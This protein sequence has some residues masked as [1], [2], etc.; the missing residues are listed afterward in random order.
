MLE[1]DHHAAVATEAPLLDDDEDDELEAMGSGWVACT[2]DGVL[3]MKENLYDVIVTMPPDYSAKAIKKVW[4]KI[5]SPRGTEM[6]A[7][8]RDLRRYVN[9]RRDLAYFIRDIQTPFSASDEN[10][11]GDD[12]GDSSTLRPSSPVDDISSVIDEKIVE[13]LSWS[14]LAYTGF[15]WWASAGERRADRDHEIDHDRSL[16]SDLEDI[17]RNAP[18]RPS[19]GRSTSTLT[20]LAKRM[21]QSAAPEMAIIVYFRRLTTLILC[22]LADIIDSTD[23]EIDEE[24]ELNNEGTFVSR[25]DLAKMG[26]DVWSDSDKAFVENVVMEYFGRHAEVDGGKIECC[27]VRIC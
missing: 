10:G 19:P 20:M 26:L 22:T 6:K 27:G 11:G 12:I 18:T 7:T 23:V 8:Q 1:E 15:M 13:P 5:E 4:P 14:A 17:E 24:D 3:A 2:T 16:L 21:C 25:D 9:L